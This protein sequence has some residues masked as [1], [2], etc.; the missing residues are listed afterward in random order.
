MQDVES[1]V[2]GLDGIEKSVLELQLEKPIE[3]MSLEEVRILLRKFDRELSFLEEETDLDVYHEDNGTESFRNDKAREAERR[4][5]VISSPNSL[6]PS[7]VKRFDELV[8]SPIELRAADMRRRRIVYDAVL[9]ITEFSEA[10]KKVGKA[11]TEKK[12]DVESHGMVSIDEAEKM[13]QG[14]ES[15]SL[16]RSAYFALRNL[17]DLEHLLHEEVQVL[18]GLVRKNAGNGFVNI[19]DVRTYYCESQ[20]PL[21]LR[22]LILK[23][24]NETKEIYDFLFSK[25]I[26]HDVVEPWNSGYLSITKD[27]FSTLEVPQDPYKL[28]EIALEILIDLGY[29]P[30]FIQDF[31]NPNKPGVFLDIEEREG[32]KPGAATFSLGPYSKGKNM[33][34]YNPTL[35]KT[36]SRRRWTVFPHEL[37]HGIHH[38]FSRREDQD[39]IFFD[40]S[41]DA[42]ETFSIFH[43]SAATSKEAL[44]KSLSQ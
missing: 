20:N 22:S 19:F 31:Y 40:E 25:L 41:T 32:K 17:D 16:R 6:Y 26:T 29:D 21:E 37:G 38:E 28:F 3:E 14:N 11:Y 13:L 2:W 7:L 9:G 1:V 39:P 24:V 15:E 30:D 43:E 12:V 4:K 35:F 27:P 18:T 42:S 5:E 36:N 33:L 34:R 8:D 44:I 23:F 10:R